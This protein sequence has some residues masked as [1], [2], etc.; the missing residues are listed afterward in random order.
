[1]VANVDNELTQWPIDLRINTAGKEMVDLLGPM[2]TTRLGLWQSDRAN[3]LPDNL[4][5]Y[6]DGVSENQ[7]KTLLEEELGKIRNTCQVKYRGR[8]PPK[9]TLIIVGKRHHT[10]FFRKT[11]A[12]NCTNPEFGTVVDTGVTEAR[13]WDFFLQSHH[14]LLGTACPAHYFV[15]HNEILT[16]EFVGAT[17]KIS[18]YLHKLA[19]E[20]CYLFGRSTGPVNIPPPVYYADLACEK[21]RCYGDCDDDISDT[22]ST[23]GDDGGKPQGS[24]A[25]AQSAS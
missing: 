7:Y 6:R 10:R 25:E 22:S 18:D 4:L 2:L 17:F 19:Y 1:M 15:L 20:M 3:S 13:N 16:K 5:I 9:I 11:E 23:I 12:G 24:R 14:A 8:D 21:S